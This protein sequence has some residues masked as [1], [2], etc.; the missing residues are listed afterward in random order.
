MGLLAKQREQLSTIKSFHNI[1]F[2]KVLKRGILGRLKAVIKDLH[3]VQKVGQY[4]QF[5]D[6]VERLQEFFRK[7]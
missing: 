2:H 4:K 6:H 3:P 7:A 1:N 5:V